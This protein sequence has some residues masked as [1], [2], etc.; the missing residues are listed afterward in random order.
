MPGSESRSDHNFR[1]A[2]VMP[3]SGDA[4]THTFSPSPVALA[5]PRA[6]AQ[7]AECGGAP[8]EQ[9][10]Q[11]LGSRPDSAGAGELA[12]DGARALAGTARE[13][14]AADRATWAAS[15]LLHLTEE[16]GRRDIHGA[17]VRGTARNEVAAAELAAT[18]ACLANTPPH[19]GAI[20]LGASVSAELTGTGLD[21]EWLRHR[22]YELTGT[23]LTV[24]V[25]EAWVRGTRLLVV[26]AP[27][28]IEPIRV[29]GRITWRVGGS[30]VPVDPTTWHAR[31][32]AELR[33]DWSAEESAVPATSAR[34]AAIAQARGFLQ[35]S[36]EVHALELA[37][38]ADAELLR[39]LNVVTGTGMLTNA[40]VL[41][42]V[43]R[44]AP[45]VDYIRREQAGGDSVIRVRRE[46]RSLLEEL[47]EAF[48]AIDVNNRTLHLR[49][50]L[51]VG[52]LNEV[53][54]L[55]AR[56][57]VVNGVAHREWAVAEPTVIE[58]VGRTLRVTS[59]GGFV[60]GVT[61][62]NLMTHPS[63]SRN[64]ALTELLAALRV[65]E[66]EGIGVD[67]MVRDM[68]A[69][70]HGLPEIREVP[71]PY[72]RT[73]LVGDALDEAWIEWLSRLQPRSERDDVNSLLILRHLVREGWADA[74]S[75]GPVI[76][77]SDAEVAG[78]LAKLAVA[79]MAG[80][81]VLV[82]VDGVPATGPRSWC[83]S[84]S[85]R[86]HLS[87]LDR[88]RTRG[89]RWPEREVVALSYARARGRISTTELASLVGASATNLGGVL[90]GL[91]DDGQLIPSRATRRGKGFYY[92]LAAA[93]PDHAPTVVR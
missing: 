90:K 5:V 21:P 41:A 2:K 76:Q 60:A 7:L 1:H 92:Q 15:A 27:R 51:S 9:V 88:L 66:R 83:L 35:D 25:T 42:F 53:P 46:G 11:P 17:L 72:V 30:C 16:P 93:Q 64:R 87:A 78:A 55:A 77:L 58:H 86:D 19:G 67:R 32:M 6:L 44:G 48:L 39:R 56:E 73:S 12:T 4:V 57:A 20:I 26:T 50:G 84:R 34:P 74:V 28:A 18:A 80:S 54:P 71:G 29:D 10:V 13:D 52:Q 24:D 43:G 3:R 81:P 38:A 59:P 89:P 40:G 33:F 45:C 49:S 85:A 8:A 61:E 75:I 79:T 70:G 62:Q 22:I 91:E 36:G 69:V 65:A 23:C 47:A 31:R 37:A 82:A 14:P 63:R 68:V